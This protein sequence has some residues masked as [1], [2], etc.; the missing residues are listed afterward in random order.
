M[1]TSAFDF[2]LP[3]ELIAQHPA[4]P[5]DR[6]RLMVIRRQEG[7]WEHRTFRDLPE[8][9]NPGDV[10]VR[11]NT[12]VVPARIIGHRESTG[13]KWEGLFLRVLEDGAWEILATT[14]GRP[15]EGETVIVGQGLRLILESKGT[16]GRWKV[17]PESGESAT[18]LLELHGQVPLPPYIR[19]GKEE[20]GDRVRYQ[21]LYAAVP[22]AVAAPTAGL[23]FTQ[24]VFE[25]LKARD[26]ALV[27]TTLHVGIGTFR[28][29]EVDQIEDHV[30]HAEWAELTPEAVETI[31]ARRDAG[32]RIVAV[33]TT[34]ARTLETA[35][36]SG[37]LKPFAGETRLYL[38][39]GHRFQ[40]MNILLTNFHLPRSSLLVLV[41]ALGGVDLIRE[42]Y[43]EAVRQRYRFYSYG[44]AMLIL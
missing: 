39:P 43:A 28:P 37:T 31:K 16:E 23:H 5:R 15:I 35:A 33:G 29:I 41:S 6:A 2:V 1:Q 44:D 22:G 27:D 18:S 34:S 10:L 4:E 9:L 36:A 14:R 20:P 25:G 8:L 17:R 42:A 26:I 32:G 11:N 3:D 30:L 21:T 24:A 7:T 40:G 19:K 13:G 12:Q 38:R